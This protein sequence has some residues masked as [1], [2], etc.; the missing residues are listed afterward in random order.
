MRGKTQPERDKI[1]KGIEV[2]EVEVGGW[3][4]YEVLPSELLQSIRSLFLERDGR[5]FAFNH[6]GKDSASTYYENPG[7]IKNLKVDRREFERILANL[8]IE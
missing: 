4:G 6:G 1:L 8:K 2:R 5:F 3:K 7:A